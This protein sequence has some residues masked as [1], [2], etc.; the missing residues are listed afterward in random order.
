MENRFTYDQSV[1]TQ[2][3]D[4]PR[5]AV[6]STV[7]LIPDENGVVDVTERLQRLLDDVKRRDHRGIVLIPEGKY[8]ISRTVYLPRA[9]RMIGYGKERP[10]FILRENTPGFQKPPTD[11]KGQAV[12]MFWFTGNTPMEDGTIQDANPGTFY[13]AVSNIDF[14]IEKGNPAAVVLRAHFAQHGFVSHCVFHIGEGKAGIFDV[15]NEME[16]LHFIGG[17][18]GMYTT[19]CSPGWPFV[20]V[21][22]E[23][24]GQREAA[25][26]SRECGLTF[27]RVRFAHVPAALTV[28]DGYWEKVCWKDCVMEDITGPAL[29]IAR[30]ENSCTQVNLR[31]VLMRRTPV[32]LLGKES[33]KTLPGRE[34]ETWIDSLCV[35]VTVTLE[36]A[37]EPPKRVW[38]SAFSPVSDWDKAVSSLREEVRLLPPQET[39]RNV[40]DWGAMGNGKHDD[41]AALQRALDEGG[42]IYLP[43][44]LYRVTDTLQMRPD[45]ALIGMNPISTQLVLDENSPAF[46]GVGPAKAVL[47][48]SAG[49]RDVV[50][51]IGIDTACR[52][53][54]AVGC[55]W[56]AGA[57]SYMNDV[58]F[59]GGHGQIT[60][61]KE[62]VPVYNA[63]RT[64][65]VDAQR[66]WDVQ[67]PSLWITDGGGGVFKDVWSASTYA[68]SGFMISET[69]T[70]GVMYQ[71]SVEHHVRHEILLRRVK[72][73]QF[74][75]MQTEEEVAEGSECQP[76]ELS[77]CRDLIFGNVYAFR[78]IWVDRPYPC[79]VKAWGCENLV[80]MNCHNFTQMKYTIENFYQDM[81]TG[82]AVGYWQ[83]SLLTVGEKAPGC[84]LPV[85][86][87]QPVLLSDGLDAAD[88]LCAGPNGTVFVCDSRLHRLYRWDPKAGALS[89]LTVLPFRPLSL[90][91]DTAGSLLMVT[92]YKPVPDSTVEGR[93]EMDSDG[94]EDRVAT[95][96]GCY[97]PFF[98]LDRQIRVCALDPEHPEDS[99]Q[100]LPVRKTADMAPETLLYPMNQWRDDGD[101][102][103]SFGTVE[104]LCYPA[105]DG[106]TAVAHH[107]GLARATGLVPLMIGQEALLVDEYNK[108]IVKVQVE[109]DFVLT[110]PHIVLERGEYSVA[111][112][113]DGTMYVPDSL[114]YGGK[115]GETPCTWRLPHRPAGVLVSTDGAYLYITAREAFYAMRLIK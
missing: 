46:A 84:A 114:L 102:M 70:P 29:R 69:E 89:L 96:G 91:C 55:R 45:S 103:M 97:F 62:N 23:F 95:S 2:P 38:D 26:Y 68:L 27:S 83:M 113:A 75:A 37:S 50:N 53:P 105:P 8:A 11:D 16:N 101:M 99:L 30:E 92:E 87:D 72:N 58:K 63:S 36:N 34:E 47:Q 82:R 10:E 115:A 24:E 111:K 71:V 51:G 14:T 7:G 33:G 77:E 20:L 86:P 65:D 39:W 85:T 90:W 4:D 60:P 66:P 22:S 25:V 15:G 48:T 31:H 93:R 73:W 28:M 40:R 3:L 32:L 78:V 6:L 17:T 81:D 59:V 74:Y 109:K 67:Y 88:G 108:C 107:P 104:P 1:Y 43:Q 35:G 110:H 80:F 42:P 5:A 19:K 44:G 106:K 54:R 61:E 49:G 18:Y 94:Y 9:V 57:D 12:Y 56:T 100:V 41:T 21:N 64:A 79:V 52:N 112:T 13:S 76:W 98:R